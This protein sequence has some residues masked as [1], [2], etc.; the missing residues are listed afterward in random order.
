MVKNITFANP[1]TPPPKK[2]VNLNKLFPFEKEQA[3]QNEGKGCNG[4]NGGWGGGRGEW[5]GDV[6]NVGWGGG[7]GGGGGGFNIYMDMI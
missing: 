5:G 7:M 4:G 3:E 2:K 6:G 1:H